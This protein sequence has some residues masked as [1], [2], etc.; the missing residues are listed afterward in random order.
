VQA[1]AAQAVETGTQGVFH[2]VIDAQRDE[3]YVADF[4]GIGAVLEQ[5][6]ELRI[7]TRPDLDALTAP[8][9]GPSLKSFGLAGSDLFPRATMIGRI[10]ERAGH[11]CP[12]S[13]LVPIYLRKT[14]FVKAPPLRPLP[15]R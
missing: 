9:I 4:E 2:I 12:A 10:A 15:D 14:A 7:L 13:D 6:K 5:R 11:I 3:F 1:L 8:L